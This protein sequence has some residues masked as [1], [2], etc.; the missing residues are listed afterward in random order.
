MNNNYAVRMASAG[1]HLE[2]VKYLVGQG[3]NAT[4]GN[5]LALQ[6]ANKNGHHEIVKYLVSQGGVAGTR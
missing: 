3:A 5:N 1:G 4:A 2:T 6:W